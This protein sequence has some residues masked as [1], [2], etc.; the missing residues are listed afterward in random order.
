M[1]SPAGR[2]RLSV[3]GKNLSM[4]EGEFGLDPWTQTGNIFKSKFKGYIIPDADKWRL[5]LLKKLLSQRRDMVACD[6]QVENIT[7]LIDSLCRT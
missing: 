6:E 4:L 2:D 1:A 5:P 7:E 3:T